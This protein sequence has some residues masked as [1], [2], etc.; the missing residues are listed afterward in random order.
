MKKNSIDIEHSCLDPGVKRRDDGVGF[1]RC[2]IM[3]G[4]LSILSN[5]I[6]LLRLAPHGLSASLLFPLYLC[7]IIMR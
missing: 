7:Y 1:G 5:S 2:S 3:P 4:R 6:T